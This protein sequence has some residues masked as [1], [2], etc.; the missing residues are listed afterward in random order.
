MEFLKTLQGIRTPLFDSIFG[1]VTHLGDE[2]FFMLISLI[3]LWCVNKKWGY[4]I[5]LIGV[6]GSVANQLLKGVFVIPRPWVLDPTFPIV[7]SAREA[8]GGY[9]F[10]SG[11]THSAVSVFGVLAMWLRKKWFTVLAVVMVLLVGFSRMY[12]GVH[13]PLDVG[14]S[15]VL[16]T[17]MV[18]GMVAVLDGGNEYKRLMS[19]TLGGFALAVVTIIY[20]CVAPPTERNIPEVDAENLATVWKLAGVLVGVM[21]SVWVDNRYTHFEVAAPLWAQIVKVL[22]G[23][24][25]VMGVRLGMKPV[26]AAVFGEQAF[27]DGV[28]YLAM[29]VVGGALWPMTFRFFRGKGKA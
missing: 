3:L 19:V 25:L 23:A 28:R 16:G 6:T 12:L 11:H 20:L 2:T 7:E 9:S 24:A 29:T 5:L 4:R 14:V 27:L 8:A 17:V 22:G 13:T 15:L 18:L 21:V 1:A 26:L 10:P